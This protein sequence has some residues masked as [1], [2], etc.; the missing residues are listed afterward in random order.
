M[1]S[2][3]IPCVG[4]EIAAD[5]YDG[6]A[7]NDNVLLILVGYA[8]SKKNHEELVTAIVKKSGYSALV[9][10]YTGHGE[11]PYELQDLSPAQNF[12]E[13]ITAYDWLA[14]NHPEKAISVMDTSYGGFMAIQLTKYRSPKKLILRVPAIYSPEAFYTKWKDMDLQ[15]IRHGYRTDPKNFI[16][17]PLLKRAA[18]YQGEPYVLTHELDEACPKPATDAIA[19]AF[20]AETW[21]AKGFKHGLGESTYTP[22]Q[23]EEYQNKLVEWLV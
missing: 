23:L 1:K 17:H 8:S 21:E 13:V 4:Y 22:V 12:L 19:K 11:S 18:L 14:D 16:D 6:A 3:K 15:E 7:D 10:D 2:F 9:I 5:W 20:N